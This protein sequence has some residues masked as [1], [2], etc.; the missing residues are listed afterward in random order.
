MNL[1]ALMEA[2]DKM[3]PG[4]YY[5]WGN[6]IMAHEPNLGCFDEPALIGCATNEDA[7]GFAMEHNSIAILIEIAKAAMAAIKNEDAWSPIWTQEHEDLHKA[8]AKVFL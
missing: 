3:T 6:T 2:R 5:S 4:K 1:T 8:I 7:S